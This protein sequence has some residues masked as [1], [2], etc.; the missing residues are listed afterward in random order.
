VYGL[1]LQ[2]F[3]G[4]HDKPESPFYQASGM[5]PE[6]TWEEATRRMA[7]VI[8]DL[9]EEAAN[10]PIE[11]SIDS[12][13]RWHALIFETTFPDDAGRLRWQL[14]GE[15]E[16]VDFGVGIGTVLSR[17]FRTISGAHPRKVQKRISTA[18]AEFHSSRE[19]L[20]A[21]ESVGIR[22]AAFAAARL[23]AKLLRI[24]PFV[25]GNLRAA[26]S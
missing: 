22:G 12:V 23:Y 13:R 25:D 5:T 24:H 15:W 2:S 10:G 3:A 16:H 8:S 26:F 17:V 1:D 20:L 14:G 21:S 4:F 6:Q 11:L 7:M 9:F 18:C 19:T